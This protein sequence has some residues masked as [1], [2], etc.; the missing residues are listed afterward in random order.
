MNGCNFLVYEKIQPI[1]SSKVLVYR[2]FLNSNTPFQI[3]LRF[4]LLHKRS[5]VKLFIRKWLF[6]HMQIIKGFALVVNF[7]LKLWES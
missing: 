1:F 7:H 5:L 6:I 2:Q 4:W 3:C